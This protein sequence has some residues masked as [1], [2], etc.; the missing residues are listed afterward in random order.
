MIGEETTFDN[1]LLSSIMRLVIVHIWTISVYS[2]VLLLSSA[3]LCFKP[4][5]WGEYLQLDFL[6][7]CLA[8][9][10]PLTTCRPTFRSDWRRVSRNVTTALSRGVFVFG[11]CE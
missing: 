3:A 8:I 5:V 10:M 11:P 1:N 9:R 7:V 2:V 4:P 6:S